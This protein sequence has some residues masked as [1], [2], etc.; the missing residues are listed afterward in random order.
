MSKKLKHLL[1]TNILSFKFN[2][3]E[4]QCSPRKELTPNQCVHTLWDGQNPA[5]VVIKGVLNPN[6]RSF[7]FQEKKLDFLK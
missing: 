5:L 6:F 2:S 3:N 4:R 7:S 1:Q